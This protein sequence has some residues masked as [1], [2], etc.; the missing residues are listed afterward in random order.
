[1][2]LFSYTMLAVLFVAVQGLAGCSDSDTPDKDAV[3]DDRGD[4]PDQT[5]PDVPDTAD[6][7]VP[8]TSEPEQ[9]VTQ[10]DGESIDDADDA[11][12]QED[13]LGDVADDD[14]ATDQEDPF[15]VEVITTPGGLPR[16]LPFK[17]EREDDADPIP[18][19]EID[20]FTDAMVKFY[21]DVD[22]FKWAAETSAG[23]DAATGK[24]DYLIWWHDFVAVK[25]GNKVT[26]RASKADGGSHNNVE[27]TGIVLINA[28][29]AHLEN[30]DD[31]GIR[32][33]AEQYTKSF[34][35]LQK[36]MV[37]DENDEVDWLFARNIAPAL[38][39]QS[40]IP[41][42]PEKEKWVEYDEWFTSYEG[43]NA[44]RFLYENQPLW[45][46]TWVTNK[47]SKDDLP[48]IYR[49]AAWL[50][51]II[52]LTEDE[53][54]RE[55]A[56][57]ALAL[58]IK[59]TKDIVDNEW[60]IRS[61]NAQGEI[62]IP[63]DIDNPD[64]IPDLASLATYV[65][66]IPDSECDAR[67]ATALLAYGDTRDQDCE[68]G[69]G[70]AFDLIAATGHYFNYAIIDNFHQ[71]AALLALT[72]GHNQVAYDLV[73]GLIIRGERYQDPNSEEPGWER[74]E[75][76]RDIALYLLRSAAVGLPLTVE[77][78]RKIQA[79]HLSTLAS[80]ADYPRWNMWDPSVE[81]GTYSFRRNGF[82]PQA[83]PDV[84]RSEDIASLFE[85]CGSPFKNPAGAQFIDCD[86]LRDYNRD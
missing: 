28:L 62:I 47:R 14:T 32:Y 22:Y 69:Q 55:V 3:V 71:V 8:D 38:A 36:G 81:D 52:E 29:V 48:Y 67:L 27:P 37:Y 24:P 80:Y 26:F 16:S 78:A 6:P 51:Y 39:H 10:D 59:G 75:W 2:R 60:I 50:P 63:K 53:T 56:T 86:K 72:T 13:C 54:L 83:G 82:H 73:R 5:D 65:A 84:M 57:E 30:P 18:Q 17:L 9:D 44:D 45:G 58:I 61:K 12:D 79:Y 41:W 4:L 43:W 35:A 46:P 49:V 40:H 66:L 11:C 33:I 76:E 20:S 31:E 19:E 23:V 25:E 42:A 7:D 21:K 15:D 74:A 34:I 70:S 64:A 77:E 85:Y 68:T 1:V